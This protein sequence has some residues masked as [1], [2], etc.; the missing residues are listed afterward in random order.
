[1]ST[2]NKQFPKQMMTHHQYSMHHSVSNYGNLQDAETNYSAHLQPKNNYT[3]NLQNP[4]LIKGGQVKQRTQ[5]ARV[6]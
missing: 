1:M 3:S 6:R 4:Y 5:F 2:T